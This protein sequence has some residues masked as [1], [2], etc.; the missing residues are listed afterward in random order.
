[1]SLPIEVIDVS[2]IERQA[3]WAG[4]QQKGSD[5]GIHRDVFPT[6]SSILN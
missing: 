2:P 5:K 1:M 3:I 6:D 4:N